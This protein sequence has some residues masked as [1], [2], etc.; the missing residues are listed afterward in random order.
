MKSLFLIVF[1]SN[2]YNQYLQHSSKQD[3]KLK[4]KLM[5]GKFKTWYIHDRNQVYVVMLF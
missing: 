3:V 1:S 5:L 4:L 2:S